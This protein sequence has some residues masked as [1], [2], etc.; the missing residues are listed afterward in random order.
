[1]CG[2]GYE[3]QGSRCIDGMGWYGQTIK[4]VLELTMK[5]LPVKMFSPRMDS[6]TVVAD[7]Y[8]STVDEGTNHVIRSHLGSLFEFLIND[9]QCIIAT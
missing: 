8:T 6:N 9:L 4:A 2:L 7:I 5:L 1:M 3:R